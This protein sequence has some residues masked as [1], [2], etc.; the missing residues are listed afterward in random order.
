TIPEY[1]TIADHP[2]QQMIDRRLSVTVSTDNRLVSH[3]T[4]T[5]ELKLLADHLTLS[6]SQFRDLV[7]AGFK[8]SFFPGPYG[9]KRAYV[10]RAIDLYDALATK[11]QG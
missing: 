1:N 5:A 7:L 4:V 3:T 2:I 8:R 10:R 6:K 9:E 11:H